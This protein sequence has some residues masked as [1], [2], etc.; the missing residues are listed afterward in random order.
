MIQIERYNSNICTAR[1][2]KKI[3]HM[4][5]W[6]VGG[7]NVVVENASHAAFKKLGKRFETAHAAA[8]SYRCAETQAAVMACAAELGIE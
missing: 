8:Q 2:G 6:T 3:L 7:F 5:R 4:V 1:F